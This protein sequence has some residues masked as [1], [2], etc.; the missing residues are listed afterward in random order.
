MTPTP[1]DDDILPQIPDPDS[2]RRRLA[3]VTT[4]A[5]LLR[6]QLRV[7]LRLQRERER[8]QRQAETPYPQPITAGEGRRDA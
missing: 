1:A 3:V 2:I 7:S 8:L 6:A 4:E 5:D